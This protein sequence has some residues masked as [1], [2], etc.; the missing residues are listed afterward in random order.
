MIQASLV[1]ALLGVGLLLLVRRFQAPWWQ[2]RGIRWALYAVVLLAPLGSVVRYIGKSTQTPTISATGSLLAA[3]FI[4]VLALYLSLPIAGFV[5][6]LGR[7]V[8]RV[9]AQTA[10]EEKRETSAPIEA[11]ARAAI[12]SP[13]PVI[14]RRLMLE[15]AV[16]AAPVTMFGLGAAGIAGGF[17]S[18]RVTQRRLSF[19]GLAPGLSG[20]RVMQI[21]DL[22]LGAFFGLGSI[23]ALVEKIAAASPDL[24]VLTGDICDHLPYLESGLR[25]IQEVIP[26]LGAYAVM[27]NHE[28]YRGERATRRIYDKTSIQMITNTHRTLDFGGEKLVLVGV[29]DPAG[30]AR[31]A[32]PHAALADRALDGAPSDGF[33]LALCHRPSGFKTLA[34]RGVDLTLSGHTHGAQVGIAER[35]VLEPFLPDWYLWGAYE[36]EGKQL[37]TSSGAGHWAAF[38]LACPSEAPIIEISRK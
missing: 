13:E 32:E 7:R 3:G 33:K 2:V 24:L 14:S 6:L 38:R 25:Q 1:T 4:L 9:P 26:K 16:A 17:D 28:Y 19:D 21:T 30:Y 36:R 11:P 27:G 23:P 5:R 18:T 34:A 15:G 31:A 37:Y 22:H 35:S 12:T 20:L 29:D 10:P 8:L